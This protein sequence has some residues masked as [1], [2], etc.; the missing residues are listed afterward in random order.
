MVV[1]AVLATEMD[2]WFTRLVKHAINKRNERRVC[3]NCDYPNTL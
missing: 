2:S 3:Y 1:A